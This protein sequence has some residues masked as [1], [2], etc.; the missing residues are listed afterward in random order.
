MTNKKKQLMVAFGMPFIICVLILIGNGVYPFGKQCI[1]HM[2]MYH[3]YCPFFIEF[4]DKLKSGGSL[5]Y[6]WNIGLGSDFVSLF[7]YY[8]ASPF[9]WLLVIC[10]KDFVIE[11]MTILI[12]LK[13]SFSGMSF[14]YFLREHFKIEK[15]FTAAYIFSLGY[16]FCGFVATY[17]WDIMWM[18]CIALAPLIILGLERLV[19]EGKPALY[20][21]TLSIS[22]LANYYMSMLICI[23]LVFYFVALFFQQKGGKLK[24]FIRFSVYS[25]LAGGTGV[26]LML[27]EMKVLSYSGSSGM[28]FPKKMEWYFNIVAELSRL[29]VSA[30]VYEG[31]DHW[32]NLY[33]GC[34][35]LLLVVFYVFNKE[36]NWKK[37]LSRIGMLAF[38]IVSFANNYLDFIW[39]G[40]HFPD[41]LPARQSFLFSF[42]ML[43]VAYDT[44]IHRKGV[45]I[46]YMV[47]SIILVIGMLVASY[48]KMDHTIT[49]P[50]CF[51]VTGIFV[52]CYG[53][54][55]ILLKLKAVTSKK[56][57]TEL[58]YVVMIAE[59]FVNMAVTGFGTTSRVNYLKYQED[60]EELLEI[61][62]N[63]SGENEFYRVENIERQTK[64]DAP[65]YGYKSATQFSS[66]MNI[67]TSHF[68]QKFYMEGGKN[69]YCYNGATPITSAMLSVKYMISDDPHGE[70]DIWTKVGK[71]NNQ[72]LYR[73]KYTLPMGYMVNDAFIQ[74]F[75]SFTLNKVMGINS[76]GY[77][78]GA[79]QETL[80][81]VEPN[82]VN[83]EG[84]T[85]IR[86]DKDGHYYANYTNCG[87]DSLTFSFNNGSDWK[88]GKTTHKYLFDMGYH[89]A[90]ESV[91]ISNSKMETIHFDVYCLNINAVEKAYSKLSQQT[92]KM[93]EYS[94]T[95]MKGSIDVKEPGRLI[96]S[97]ESQEGWSLL[98]DGREQDI[99]T[100][101]DTFISVDLDEGKH[102]IELRYVTP[103]LKEGAI[104][105]G[106][107]VGI[108]IVLMLI[109]KLR[110]TK[111]EAQ[112][113]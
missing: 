35:V 65:K 11:F 100:F 24:A 106:A 54:L 18:D 67:N 96:L 102:E 22:I 3:Q 75:E 83:K 61:A 1:L 46:R 16:A 92:M 56:I 43:V 48:K 29:C 110:A 82:Q 44:Y 50:L 12:V 55:F 2:D 89:R 51:L 14:F 79:E 47:L 70:S 25:L 13:I 34:F 37:K 39:H 6:S 20:Y 41:S 57:I 105:S 45:R 95:H 49:E 5:M 59:I 103:G 93:E 31:N 77:F 94:D 85:V 86:F 113:D 15:D 68:Y 108:F 112:E 76:I 101:A 80:S 87:A 19:K 104:F 74:S 84:S 27:P 88:Y 97:I 81:R 71:S 60:Y 73:N 58:M 53:A 52:A 30:E 7:A 111:N 99:T 62:K 4:L 38:F 63:D 66:L 98:V 109:R 9:N 33:S 91:E 78:L 26:I 40:L 28:S 36:I 23:F 107:C 32:P 10:P 42:V 90:G 8:L 17:S 64:N 21:I 72:Y 69:Y